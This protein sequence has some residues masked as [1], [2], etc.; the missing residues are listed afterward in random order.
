ML[1]CYHK[2]QRISFYDVDIL[3]YIIW[4]CEKYFIFNYFEMIQTL[5]GDIWPKSGRSYDCTLALDIQSTN[6]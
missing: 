6:I 3:Y 5:F 1:V 2:Y 4:F